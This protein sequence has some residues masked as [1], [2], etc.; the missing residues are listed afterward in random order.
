[1]TIS[2]Q[3]KGD[4]PLT[5]TDTQQSAWC[6]VMEPTWSSQDACTSKIY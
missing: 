2:Q 4:L 6:S 3:Y 1:M 5:H